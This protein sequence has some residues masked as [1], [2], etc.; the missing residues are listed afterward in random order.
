MFAVF[1][2]K[3]LGYKTQIPILLG[4]IVMML[5]LTYVFGSSFSAG[6]YKAR[7]YI[8]D[9]V[10][11]NESKLLINEFYKNDS[12]NIKITSYDEA[13]SNIENSRGVGAIII[14]KKIDKLQVSFMKIMDTNET[15]TVSNIIMSTTRA[16][17]N[18]VS[19][20][21]TTY[22]YL[23][24]NNI[25]VDIK[26]LEENSINEINKLRQNKTFYNTK[27]SFIN[28]SN[29]NYDTRKHSLAG[30]ALFFSM[31]MV[32]F[33]IG[34]I[35]DE[36]NN[37]VWQRQL[38]SPIKNASIM[39]ANMLATIIIGF[40]NILVMVY[41]GKYLFNISWGKTNIGILLVLVT[42]IFAVSCLGL[43]I[44]SF[45]KNQ[46]QLSSIAPVII[47]STSMLGGTMWPLEMIQSKVLLFLADL[48]PQKWA[49]QSIEKMIMYG[50]G[51]EVTIKPIIVLLL[52]G[53][54]YLTL[55]VKLIKR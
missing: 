54:V 22:N 25:N 55:G 38:V 30:F 10:K 51:I 50:G 29:N 40:I 11:T 21:D 52:M 3:L 16:Y 35:I 18:D 1:K 5:G 41:A 9:N 49:L 7:V 39:C 37:H 43:F 45:L 14:D 33:G 19:L 4:F 8:V 17:Q 46:Q 24:E 23:H 53:L 31:F 32:F 47:V 34:T 36:K 26:E 44:S 12:L 20:V 13:V 6:S 15:I 42:F 48:T 2:V 27:A 28:G